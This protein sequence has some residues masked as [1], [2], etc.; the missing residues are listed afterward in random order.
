MHPASKSFAPAKEFDK[1]SN[2]PVHLS[3]WLLNQNDW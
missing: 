3:A 2:N 1:F